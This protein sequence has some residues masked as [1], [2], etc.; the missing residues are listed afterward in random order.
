LESDFIA[1]KITPWDAS[2]HKPIALLLKEVFDD[3]P[4]PFCFNPLWLQDKMAV[5]IIRKTWCNC[6]MSPTS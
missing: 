5:D 6:V 2:A 3:G 1:S 4:I